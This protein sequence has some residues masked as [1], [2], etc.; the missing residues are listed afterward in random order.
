MNSP[1]DN[2]LLSIKNLLH[3]HKKWAVAI[4]VIIAIYW[5]VSYFFNKY[6]SGIIHDFVTELVKKQSGGFYE[7]SFDDAGYYVFKRRFHV[8]NLLLHPIVQSK[9]QNR[10]TL[11]DEIF[12]IS[13][14]NI[15]IRFSGLWQFLVQKKL[16]I[17]TIDIDRPSI[18]IQNNAADKEPK[19]ISFEIG[20]LYNLL[21]D[22]L[23]D[24]EIRNFKINNGLLN[25]HTRNSNGIN[26]FTIKGIN[27]KIVNFQVDEKAGARKDK[28]FYADDI[29][30]SIEDEILFLKDSLHEITFDKFYFSTRENTLGFE[31][32]K[33]GRINAPTTNPD[34]HNHYEISIP[35]L[36]FSGIDFLTAHNDNQLLIDTVD[37]E[38]PEIV[39]IKRVKSGQKTKAGNAISKSI[40]LNH[41]FVKI[42]HFNLNNAHVNLKDETDGKE[43]SFSINHVSAYLDNVKLDTGFREGLT[44]GVSFDKI[45]LEITDF[46]RILPDENHIMK[47]SHFSITNDPSQISL[48]DFHY[49]PKDTYRAD[50]KSEVIIDVPQLTIDDFNLARAVKADSFELPGILIQNPQIR[51]L[52]ALIS[53]T[54]TASTS[55]TEGLDGL[56]AKL[57]TMSRLFAIDK[58]RI[59][60]GQF[61]LSNPNQDTEEQVLLKDFS[62]DLFNFQVD[63][64]TKG[65]T[66]LLHGA[67]LNFSAR[68]GTV[69][70]PKGDI[71]FSTAN[72]STN[73]GR[74]RVN[75]LTAKIGEPSSPLE[76]SLNF[77][78][79][80]LTGI[81]PDQIIFN[82]NIAFDSLTFRI[83]DAKI[84]QHT[85]PADTLQKVKKPSIN[86]PKLTIN[87]LAAQVDQFRFIKDS[88]TVYRV[89]NF[90]TMILGFIIDKSLSDKP[91]N[92]FD[93]QK[94]DQISVEDYRLYIKNINH[95]FKVSNINWKGG[96]SALK[97]DEISL[98]PYAK[99][100]N[101][102]KIKIP[103]VTINGLDLKGLLKGS[104]Y[105]GD[106]I[107]IENPSIN[108]S[109]KES[110]Q[111]K[112]TS[113]DLGF[114][115]LLLR[116]RFLGANSRAFD[117]RSAN[118]VFHQKAP[119]DSVFF[120]ADNLNLFVDNFNLDSTTVMTSERFLFANDI[121]LQG[122]YLSAYQQSNSNFYNINHF[123]ISTKEKDIRLNGLYYGSNTKDEFKDKGKVK[124]TVENLNLIDFNFFGLTQNKRIELG[125]IM[126]DRARMKLTPPEN[127]SEE[128]EK[129]PEKI[130]LYN[131]ALDTLLLKNIQVNRLLVSHSE[132]IIENPESGENQLVIPDIWVLAENIKYNPAI[133][134]DSSRLFYSDNLT[135]RLSN[136]NYVLPDNLSKIRIDELSMNTSDSLIQ[137]INFALIPLASKYDFGPSKGY[138]TTWLHIE[139]DSIT[140]QDVDFFGILNKKRF[141]A[142]SISVDGLQISAFRDKRVPF[143]EWQRVPLPQTSLK[144]MDFTINVDSI[145]LNGGFINYQEHVEKAFSP[146]E[147]FFSKLEATIMNLTNDSIRILSNPYINIGAT[148]DVFG[149][150]HIIANFRFDMKNPENIHTY[151]VEVDAFDLT[152]FNRIMIP[153]AAVRITSGQNDKIIMSV[154]ANQDY[155]YGDMKFYYQ[156]LKIS[157][158][159]RE[160]EKPK[161]LGNMLGSFFANTFIIK[162]DNPKNFVFRKGDIFYERDEKKAIFNY[163][164]KSFLSGVVSSIGAVNNKKKIKKM[165]K[166]RLK[167]LQQKES[168]TEIQ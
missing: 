46:D 58:L 19:K 34:T 41:E 52:P 168:E 122:D 157:L 110:K 117:V 135:T 6:S 84:H 11:R 68:D 61:I 5:T 69:K 104:Y 163:W 154:K 33:L 10:N 139:N 134:H 109:L 2:P 111:Q 62:V 89:N 92:Q 44:P 103:S 101:V 115:P 15:E 24:L 67:T 126:V 99:T 140:A 71:S 149:K 47:F 130:D 4:V 166:E 133:V 35:S 57:Q 164:V 23:I 146:G 116:N 66:S 49:G 77:N 124:I 78:H 1:I 147:I 137:V 25:L 16:D 118:I 143:P 22:Y 50:G 162:S 82:K 43:K 7:V 96:K 155:S 102:Y 54:K 98:A 90:K 30:L 120:E 153:N 152:E 87:H 17:I 125:E 55:Q 37:I 26:N 114:I 106:E 81:N 150:G 95:L 85:S 123:Y 161:G 65:G 18:K 76:N 148:A 73:N 48:T 56:Y 13:V 128:K 28:F 156:D 36:H 105:D 97:I 20:N 45:M 132:A 145:K 93:Y 42:G 29:S 51:I 167:Q 136:V 38:Q 129:K 31:N 158:I 75:D 83:T 165:E 108:F 112:L 74:F 88:L 27:F 138:Q 86:L 107:I 32:L 159:N 142:K 141:D 12:N 59:R 40:I 79:I 80:T 91:I 60:Q 3:R 8:S 9:S 121:R 72:F 113:L 144:K 131:Y 100:D 160:T 127:K 70:L 63:S 64:T 94:I 39:I 119:K 53:T 21:S 14:P 151:G